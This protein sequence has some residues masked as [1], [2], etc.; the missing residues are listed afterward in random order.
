MPS[1]ELVATIERLPAAAF[2]G[3]AFRHQAAQ[4]DPLSG[5]GAR[6][7][8][9][10]WNPPDSFSV[11]YLALDEA[12]VALE[13][14]RHAARHGRKVADFLPRTL[15]GYDLALQDIL[16]LRDDSARRAVGLTVA[17]I[18][19]DDLR[20]CER[21]GEAAQH[22]GSEGILAPSAAGPGSVLAVFV[23]SISAGSSVEPHAL[24]T[25]ESPGDLA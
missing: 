8:G 15:Y 19:A 10:R 14:L 22:A 2:A 1:A 5:R 18:R 6:I 25:W 7:N 12:T 9:G 16:D 20:A 23:D 4:Y 21:V 24:G 3:R 11:L 17:D 13:F